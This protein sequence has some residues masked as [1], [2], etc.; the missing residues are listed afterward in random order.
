MTSKS[1]VLLTCLVAALAMGGHS[2]AAPQPETETVAKARGF[3]ETY[4]GESRLLTQATALLQQALAANPK[5][6]NVYVQAARV[7]SFGGHINYDNFEPGT[8]ELAEALTD[9]ALAL[10]PENAKAHILKA[11]AFNRQ[12]NWAEERKSL[13]RAKALGTKDPWLMIG[14]GRHYDSLNDPSLS[15]HFYNSVVERGP[16]ATPSERKAYVT[17]L[18][19]VSEF[20]E[21]GV[22]RQE[23]LRKY[24]A[25]SVGARYPTDAWTP[26]SYAARFIDFAMFDDAIV[27]A[28]V[29]LKTMNFG[30]GRQTLA[31]ALYGKAAQLRM[32]GRPAAELAPLI[33]EARAFGFSKG[34][35]LEYLLV[36]RGIENHT[37]ALEAALI[38]VIPAK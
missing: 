22:S 5:D 13:D 28:R 3:I 21:P 38:E 23:R 17:A 31:A 10:D 4:Y 34:A 12:K 35:I 37:R 18:D 36:R 11:I 29:A 33:S 19:E 1:L 16:G 15:Y 20:K 14:Y 26:H 24:A 8:L 7:T 9:K 6:S 30:A 32:A 27:Y 25:L 2:H